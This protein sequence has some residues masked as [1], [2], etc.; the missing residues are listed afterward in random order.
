MARARSVHRTVATYLWYFFAILVISAAVFMTAAR[1]LLPEAKGY[2][3]RVELWAS[4]VLGQSVRIASMDA[5]LVGI[6]PTLTFKGVSLLDRSGTRALVRF[7]EAEI[8]IGVL[9]SLRSWTIVPSALT[10]RGAHLAVTRLRDGRVLVRGL[11]VAN[12]PGQESGADE[13][14]HREQKE[15]ERGRHQFHIVY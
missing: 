8:G 15:A 4:H 13:A 11:D 7:D 10:V 2:R 5:S 6:T 1:L 3:E 14:Q 12:L 9:S